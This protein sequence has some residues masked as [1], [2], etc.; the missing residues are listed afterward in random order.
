MLHFWRFRTLAPLLNQPSASSLHLT[1]GSD[2][3][4]PSGHRLAS[5]SESKA[6]QISHGL[7]R[8]TRCNRLQGPDWVQH[9]QG[10]G[11]ALPFPFGL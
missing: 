4:Q 1:S 7:V 6:N 11:A 3:Q 5:Q 2:A 8:L 10:F 9:L